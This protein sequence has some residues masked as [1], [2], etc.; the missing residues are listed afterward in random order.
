[1]NTEV[2]MSR[3]EQARQ[4]FSQGYN[5]AQAVVLAFSDLT[6]LDKDTLLKLS[7][8]F[9]GGMGRMRE[10]CGTVSGMMMVAGLVFYDAGSASNKEKSALYAREQELAK[11]FRAENGSIIC[12]ELLAGVKT[13]PGPQAE[14]RTPEYYKKRPCGE[15]CACAA[16]ILEDYL[17]KEGKLTADGEKQ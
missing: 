6:G 3:A 11:R 4:Y 1:M 5:C 9:G 7:A 15:L 17:I 2:N 12:R 14:E 16:Q 10:V 13:Q 8:P